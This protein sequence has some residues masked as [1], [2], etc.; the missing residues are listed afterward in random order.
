[1]RLDRENGNSLWQW[2]IKKEIDNVKVAFHLMEEGEKLPWRSKEIPYHII[3]DVKLDLTRK[4]RLVA[5]GHR[6]K[7]VPT[8][9]AFSS[10]ASRDSLRLMFLIAAM[11]D[12]KLLSADI[13]NAYLN[14]KFRER[15]HVRCGPE[16]F[17]QEH[18]GKLV[19]I[20]RALNGLK[21]SGASWGQH[22]SNEINNLGVTNTKGDSDIYR[23]RASKTTGESYYEYLIVYVDDIICVSDN[24]KHKMDTLQIS[25]RLRDV[26]LPNKF[27]GSNIKQWRYTD[28]NGMVQ[29]CWALGSETYVKEACK[30][31]EE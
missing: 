5:G 15:V 9:T 18:A 4:S 29:S 27:L 24:P 19:F 1:M 2:A 21:T 14:A 12:L 28:D 16:L 23:R 22:L 13:G 26:G 10:V 17:G 31:A 7:D 20:V 11:N 3:F 8:Y 25:Y 30:V 6:N